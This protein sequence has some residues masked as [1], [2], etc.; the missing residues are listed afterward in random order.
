MLYPF[1][2]LD[3]YIKRTIIRIFNSHVMAVLLDGAE[4]WKLNE[5][6]IARLENFQASGEY[7]TS[8]SGQQRHQSRN[9]TVKKHSQGHE[10][11]R[12]DAQKNNMA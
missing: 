5:Y 3:E 9:Y 4:M 10:R 8:S 1:W 6:D 12:E 2:R 11:E 7:Y